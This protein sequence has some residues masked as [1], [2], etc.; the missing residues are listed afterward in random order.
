MTVFNL[1]PAANASRRE[2]LV[3]R[4]GQGLGLVELVGGEALET[5]AVV[6]VAQQQVQRGL[7]RVAGD[8]RDQLAPGMHEPRVSYAKLG[9]LADSIDYGSMHVFPLGGHPGSGGA[10]ISLH[11]L[12]EEA[13]K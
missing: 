7:V 8:G 4:G 6:D 3:F 10:G 1:I 12:F 11:E 13:K 2:G 9:S 5:C